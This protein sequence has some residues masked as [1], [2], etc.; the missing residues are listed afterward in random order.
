MDA[1]LF[2]TSQAGKSTNVTSQNRLNC[3]IEMQPGDDRAN[4]VVYGTSGKTLFTS[5]GDTPI[6]GL[7]Q[8]ADFLYVVHRGTFYSVNNAGVKVALGTIGTTS[9]RVY[10]ADN[11]SQLMIVDGSLGYIYN[12]NT[13][14]F[15]QIVSA[16]FPANVRAVTMLDDYFIV[17]INNSQRFYIS[18]IAD[19]LTWNALDFASASSNPDDIVIPVSDNSNLY[20][21][22]SSST[23][24]WNNTG[25]ANFPIQRIS[26][27][28]TEWGC[29][30]IN[31]I[32]K[33]DNSL[34]FIAKNKMGQVIVARMNGYLPMKISTPEIEF[35]I[36]NYSTVSDCTGIS[37]MLGGHPMYQLNFPSANASWLYDG[38]SQCWSNLKSYQLERDIAEI[39]VNYLNKIIIS[40][41]AVG[42]LYR[43]DSNIFTEN[44][45]PLTF[46]ITSRHI[47]KDD[48][49]I[50]VDKIQL[51]VEAGVGVITGQ[52]SNPQIMMSISKD[53][54]HTYGNEQ[55]V[56]LGAIGKYKKRARWSR[57]GIARDWVLKFRITDPVKRVILGS[58]IDI[59]I[60]RT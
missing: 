7:H 5:F 49:R 10:M 34:A 39:G 33:F 46:E 2:G 52:G 57:Q 45:N 53:G 56:T 35:I 41:Y 19:G 27:G 28:A 16:G 44:G 40:D 15:T 32:V 26:G 37:Y 11:S 23:E 48:K 3:Y 50:I 20:L 8:K 22:G 38:L 21:F 43:L 25:A 18:A 24:F 55:W 29:A 12:F 14:V 6:R 30:A 47:E 54:G 58:S 31:S 9:G 51:D 4:V 59:R 36:N 13:G 60:G 17:N 42:N 1:Q